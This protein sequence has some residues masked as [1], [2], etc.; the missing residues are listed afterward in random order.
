VCHQCGQVCTSI[1]TARTKRVIVVPTCE[2]CREKY[3]GCC[4]D[5][6]K[7]V[8]ALPIEEQRL[9]RKE[10]PREEWCLRRD[11]LRILSLAPVI[12]SGAKQSDL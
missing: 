5:E 12:A 1:Q 7:E 8:I 3:N 4:S 2:T 11:G 6:C 9:L 10:R